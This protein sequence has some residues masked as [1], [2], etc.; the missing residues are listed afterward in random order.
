MA[1]KRVTF[2]T[3]NLASNAVGR[4]YLLARMLA[5][6]FDVTIVGPGDVAQRWTPLRHDTAFEW[7]GFKVSGAW[8]LR[9]E[10]KKIIRSLIDGDVIY[11]CKP[12][13]ASFG[14]GLSARK[15]LN[16][17]LLLD[18]DDWELGFI[19]DS[20]YWEVRLFKQRWLTDLNSPLYTRLLDRRMGEAD[21][22][23]VSSSFLQKRYGGHWV[24]HSRPVLE[25]TRQPLEGDG[26]PTV[27]FAGSP[28][29]NKGL[30]I[31]LK[32][33]AKLKHPSARLRILGLTADSELARNTPAEVRA[34]VDF[35]DPIPY[36]KLPGF[37]MSTDVIVIPQKATNASIGQ[38]PMKLMDAMSAGRAIVST[39]VSDI[40]R[41][42]ADGAGVV[43]EPENVE[44]LTHA[45]D[46]LLADPARS[47]K[48]GALA[49]ARYDIFGA[50]RVVGS[51]LCELV[52]SLAEGKAPPKPLPA[53]DPALAASPAVEVG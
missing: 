49:R 8:G 47:Q 34:R 35:L 48:M 44:A 16:K 42:L 10:R 11:A 24:P 13:N 7:R 33:W 26:P 9:R 37:L 1:K 27:A 36:E 31:L 23:T 30:D 46:K 15:W 19:S 29:Q 38:L 3:V 40:P 6:E 4:T 39:E 45:L 2:L 18:N 53:F 28:R 41:W 20:L 25:I 32:A 50:D 22:M 43:I 12:I 52:G 17:P 14:L 5:P 51:R 21:A